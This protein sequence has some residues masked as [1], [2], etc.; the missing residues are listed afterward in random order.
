VALL[1]AC[2]RCLVPLLP[3]S[4]RQYFCLLVPFPAFMLFCLWPG[5]L[6]VSVSVL[7]LCFLFFALVLC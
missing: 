5:F 2:L 4:G 6:T 7:S 3:S 1:H